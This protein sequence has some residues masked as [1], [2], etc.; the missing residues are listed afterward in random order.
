MEPSGRP[1]IRIRFKYN[2]DTGEIEEFIID[3]NAPAAR[4]EY[5]DKVARVI[6]ARVARH[7]Q[8]EDAGPTRLTATFTE[9]QAE[10]LSQQETEKKKL[11]E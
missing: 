5:H 4:D 3:D 9:R 1:A 11:E 6:A 7:P 10:Q 2:R 8:V